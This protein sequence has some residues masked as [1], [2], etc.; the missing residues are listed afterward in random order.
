MSEKNITPAAIQAAVSGNIENFIAAS[1]PGG[2]EAQEA[3][4]QQSFTMIKL[5]Q[6]SV[7][8][9]CWRRSGSFL[10]MTKMIFL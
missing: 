6:K 7:H 8:V 4:G 2:I 9:K 1:T 3:A 5:C 10:V